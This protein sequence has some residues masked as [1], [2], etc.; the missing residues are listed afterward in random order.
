MY[1]SLIIYYNKQTL[2]GCIITS[3]ILYI[4][5]VL[6]FALSLYSILS[7]LFSPHFISSCAHMYH[8][9]ASMFVYWREP[10]NKHK[11]CMAIPIISWSSS[12]LNSSWFAFSFSNVK[13]ILPRWETR[14]VPALSGSICHVKPFHSVIQ[15]CRS[16]SLSRSV[17]C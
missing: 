16:C 6:F 10:R 12:A 13:A 1:V 15:G 8:Y 9:S 5:T 11:I 7:S 14:R 4:L 17:T 3:N 2:L